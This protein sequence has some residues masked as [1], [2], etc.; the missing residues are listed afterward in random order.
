MKL[1]KRNGEP[2]EIGPITTTHYVALYAHNAINLKDEGVDGVVNVG[3]DI[4]LLPDDREIKV[5]K[6]FQFFRENKIIPEPCSY[7]EED[8]FLLNS[9]W[10][11]SEKLVKKIEEN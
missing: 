9:L 5:N 2:F 11:L 10:Q 4:E 1:K 7:Y 3:E 8:D 6:I